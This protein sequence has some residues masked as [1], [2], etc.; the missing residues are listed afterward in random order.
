[1]HDTASSTVVSVAVKVTPPIAAVGWS[2]WGFTLQDVAAIFAITYSGLMTL[3]LLIDRYNKHRRK[4]ASHH[5]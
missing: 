5:P 2:H 1:M 3:F 4:H